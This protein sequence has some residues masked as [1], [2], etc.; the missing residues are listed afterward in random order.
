MADAIGC[1]SGAMLDNLTRSLYAAHGAGQ[2]NDDEA[3]QLDE[4]IRARRMLGK[5]VAAPRPGAVSPVQVQPNQRPRAVS[6]AGS[7]PRTPESVERRRAWAARGFLPPQLAKAFTQG[8]AA[9]LAVIAQEVAK[10]GKCILAI[11]AIAAAA[12][13]SETTVKRAMRHARSLALID[14]EERRVSYTRSDTNVVRITSREWVSWLRV[15][16]P[17]SS[18]QGEGAK[19]RLPRVSGST[20]RE[21]NA[22]GAIVARGPL[23]A[24][25]SMPAPLRPRGA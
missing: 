5:A 19:L 22:V 20:R 3:T 16:V 2:I 9:A 8:E 23:Q 24:V 6:R 21:T 13:V 17:G 14:V 11:G 15:R 25:L 18:P 7:R 10:R 12:G 4:A 1:A